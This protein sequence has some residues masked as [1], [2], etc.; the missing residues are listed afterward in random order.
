MPTTIRLMDSENNILCKKIVSNGFDKDTELI[1]PET[2]DALIFVGGLYLERYEPGTHDLF[3]L[4]HRQHREDELVEVVYFSKTVRM[5]FLWGTTSPVVKKIDN[6]EY[7]IKGRGE[8]YLNISN[9]RK[10]YERLIG[11][12]DL[13]TVPELKI[14]ILESIRSFFE[15]AVNEVVA[16]GI[17]TF[18]NLNNHKRQISEEMERL[19]E[20]KYEGMGIRLFDLS[21]NE[22]EIEVKGMAKKFCT[23]CGTPYQ[24]GARFCSNCGAALGQEEGKKCPTCSH[25][26]ASNARFCEVCGTKL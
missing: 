18:E 15:E 26:N 25:V 24:D 17:A 4:A 12:K 9:P 21:V 8:G 5:P 19:F 11:Q 13:F 6:R 14:S 23:A 10:A 16:Q 3:E 22:I 7:T 2:H 1:V 20:E